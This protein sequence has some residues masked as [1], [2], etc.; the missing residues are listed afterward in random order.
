MKARS[1]LTAHDDCTTLL[2]T[3][4]D[5]SVES[6][7]A[8][9]GHLRRTCKLDEGLLD[10]VM[11]GVESC[12]VELCVVES[13]VVESWVE[14]DLWMRGMRLSGEAQGLDHAAWTRAWG[15]G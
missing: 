4:L 13:C 2:I 1:L 6:A 3:A 7:G 15:S 9:W 8:V 14:V 12:G 11:G 5:H 10:Q